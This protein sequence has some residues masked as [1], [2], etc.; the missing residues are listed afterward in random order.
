MQFAAK[1]RVERTDRL[2]R[3]WQKSLRELKS[4]DK[5]E[6]KLTSFTSISAVK[7]DIFTKIFRT[8]SKLDSLF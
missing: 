1:A 3:S 6:L 8:F 7:E 5:F 2:K 4:K